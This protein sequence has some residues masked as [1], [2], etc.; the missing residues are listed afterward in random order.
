MTFHWP[1]LT[2][3]GTLGESQLRLHNLFSQ[4]ISLLCNPWR[5]QSSPWSRR[6]PQPACSPVVWTLLH[7]SLTLMINLIGSFLVHIVVG[8]IILRD[9]PIPSTI[10]QYD[11]KKGR[12]FFLLSVIFFLNT[13]FT[14]VICPS[15]LTYFNLTNGKSQNPARWFQHQEI[16]TIRLKRRGGKY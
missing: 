11:A 13:G 8:K 10:S 9:V 6:S 16:F 5:K 7:P 14:Y 3:P 12:N 4:N 1:D 2:W 15:S